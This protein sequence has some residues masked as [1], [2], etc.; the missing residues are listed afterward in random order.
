MKVQ[1]QRDAIYDRTIHNSEVLIEV[2]T[3][4]TTIF[5]MLDK[6][7]KKLE[8]QNGSL[9]ELFE[10]RTK[11]KTYGTAVAIVLPVVVSILM[12]LIWR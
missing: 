1:E 11:V 2:R 12:K 8:V 3:Q 6:I 9:K 5:K 7:D 10:F 4:Q